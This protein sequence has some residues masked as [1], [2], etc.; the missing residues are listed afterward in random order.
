MRDQQPRQGGRNQRSR[1]RGRKNTNPLGRNY[2][3]N[4]PDIK[5]RGTAQHIAE[6]YANL[7]RDM[8]GSG[9]R[10]MAENY[11]QHAEHYFRIVAAAQPQPQAQAPTTNNSPAQDDG[12]SDDAAEDNEVANVE[13]VVAAEP[14]QASEPESVDE[15]EK[16]QPRRRQPRAPRPR[17]QPSV[18]SAS[19]EPSE[20]T[21]TKDVQPTSSRS[22]NQTE[23]LGDAAE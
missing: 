15:E 2:E 16:R 5:V 21:I 3:S 20:G 9:D 1:S 19:D 22:D 11:L 18:V 4:G 14:A 12:N 8:S 7:A 23:P 17:R 6:K 13:E 10:V